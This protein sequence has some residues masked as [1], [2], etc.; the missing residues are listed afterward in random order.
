MLSIICLTYDNYPEFCSTLDSIASALPAS[1]CCSIEVVVV[2]SSCDDVAAQVSAKL[3]FLR[4][5]TGIN[6][7]YDLQSPQGIYPAM[8]RAISISSGLYLHFLNSGDAYSI[9]FDLSMLLNI[10]NK[11][12]A[13]HKT[14]TSLPSLVYGRAVI[15]SVRNTRL[16]WLNP[17][18]NVKPQARLLWNRMIPP[19]HQACFFLRSWHL[20]NKYNLVNGLAADRRII[21][22]ALQSS[23]FID[24][25]VCIFYLS[26]VT[27]LY[28]LAPSGYLKR[29]LSLRSLSSILG[30]WPKVLLII[31]FNNNW[32]FFRMYRLYVFSILIP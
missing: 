15:Q 8:N 2:D 27:S 19:S 14:G 25:N 7:G 12:K 18:L 11:I 20:D 16:S 28:Q 1:Q 21:H 4:S 24:L 6:I 17:P 13:K 9:D 30:F 32:E 3:I 22:K 29:F 23:L 26:G 5:A 10:L 31:L